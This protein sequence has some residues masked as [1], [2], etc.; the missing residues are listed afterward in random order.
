MG[1]DRLIRFSYEVV[2]TAEGGSTYVRVLRTPT[3]AGRVSDQKK[4]GVVV[5]PLRITLV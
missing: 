3:S 1:Q 5:T 2:V 4:E